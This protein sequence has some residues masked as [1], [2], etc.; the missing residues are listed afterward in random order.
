MIGKKS[1]VGQQKDPQCNHHSIWHVRSCEITGYGAPSFTASTFCSA[2][3]VPGC[4]ASK[5][6][7]VRIIT[8][9]EVEILGSGEAHPKIWDPNRLIFIQKFNK[10]VY[11][12]CQIPHIYIYIYVW[13][14]YK[15]LL[16][17]LNSEM[18]NR[19][20][21]WQWLLMYGL[22][23]LLFVWYRIHVRAEIIGFQKR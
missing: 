1:I 10:K 4:A 23:Y 17:H 13:R 20:S 21:D 22:F 19:I 2:K 18:Y 7:P 3:R 8:P 12:P 14:V 9:K 5:K 11:Y 15:G 16:F 6:Y